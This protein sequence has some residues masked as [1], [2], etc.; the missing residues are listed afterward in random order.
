MICQDLS[1]KNINRQIGLIRQ[2]FKWAAA[3]QLVPVTVWTRS[4]R[5]PG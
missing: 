4:A 5:S 2:V 1:R 3:K